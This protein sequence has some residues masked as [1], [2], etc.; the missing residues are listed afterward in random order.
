MTKKLNNKG[1]TIYELFAVIL[2]V[3][4]LS[5]LV[6][7][8]HNII[9][10]NSRN[11]LRQVR[12]KN[13]QTAL[14]RYYSKNGHYP[15]LKDINSTSFRSNELPGFN[16]NNLLDPKSKLSDGV[17]QLSSL[18]QTGYI[19]YQVSDVNGKSCENDDTLCSKYN[20]VATYEGKVNKS[21]T[22]IRQNID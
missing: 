16:T 22:Y 2:A 8:A 13:I 18:P 10:V 21:S 9:S 5:W 17:V 1:F 14:E 20:I 3:V 6:L 11:S 19:A 4:F 7:S 15:S 12:V